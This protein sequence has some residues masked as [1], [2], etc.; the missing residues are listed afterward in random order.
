MIR[1]ASPA[2]FSFSVRMVQLPDPGGATAMR[3][4]TGTRSGRAAMD[5]AMGRLLQ[6]R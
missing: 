2:A 5:V 1:S 3:D 4:P 6:I